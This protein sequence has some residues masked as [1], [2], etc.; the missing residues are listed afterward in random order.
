MDEL[1]VEKDDI[2]GRIAGYRAQLATPEHNDDEHLRLKL[3][4]AL[5]NLKINGYEIKLEKAEADG[6]N[7]LS[8]GPLLET[9]KSARDNLAKE[10]LLLLQL[11]EQRQAQLQ[12]PTGN[13]ILFSH[14]HSSVY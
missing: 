14:S 2:K 7:L 6:I 10:Q 13:S 9:I 1:L 4:I 3:E 5:L 12:P 8:L 11:Q